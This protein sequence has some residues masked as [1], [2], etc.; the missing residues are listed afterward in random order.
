MEQ[1]IH[2]LRRRM[3]ESDIGAFLVSHPVNRRYVTG[4][5]GSSGVALITATEAI[6][7]TDFRY[8]TQVKEQAPHMT[9]VQ[10]K[11][12][13][14]ETVAE[15]CRQLGVKSL[16][17]EQDHLTFSQHQQLEGFLNGIATDPVSDIVE[18][19][20]MI[21]D[22]E[23]LSVIRDAAL[24]AD[25]AF[26]QIIQEIKPGMKEKDVAL[27]L[28]ILM[29][30]M[31]ASSSSFDIIVASGLRSALPHGTASDKVL[32]KGDL[33]T[34]DF[35]AYYQ[36]Y[37][38]DITRT[39]MLGQPNEK[40]KEIYDVVLEAQKCCIAQIRPGITGREADG[41]ARDYITKHG[42]GD[43][44]G[45]GTGH[46]LGLEVHEAPRLSIHGNTVL[47]PGMVVTVEPGIYLP[48]LGGVRIEDD[49]L[50]TESGCEVLTHAN[51]ELIMID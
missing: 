8:L 32:E 13:I 39:I 43:S 14:L 24:I 48:E 2:R 6:L 27:R 34:M 33:V 3:E 7:I 29:R 44:F 47:A 4:F 1:R 5:T 31:G 21:K 42:Y 17:F 23:E 26:Y 25:R 51:K 38:S 36:G 46:G 40:Q 10:H 41:V 45:H 19:L 15:Q 22:E 37:A 30:E 35:G 50:I 12:P 20:R 16:A 18:E 28:E 11:G 9:L 49:V